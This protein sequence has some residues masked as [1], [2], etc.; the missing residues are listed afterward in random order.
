MCVPLCVLIHPPRVFSALSGWSAVFGGLTVGLLQVVQH[1]SQSA[2]D[3]IADAGA[4]T[5]PAPLQASPLIASYGRTGSLCGG[6]RVSR[7]VLNGA[8]VRSPNLSPIASG[9][10][11]LKMRVKREFLH[12]RTSTNTAFKVSAPSISSPQRGKRPPPLKT[13]LQ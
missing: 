13:H 3:A 10:S 8:V 7:E 12:F 1:W 5:L 6:V 11:V 4:I 2:I 9:F